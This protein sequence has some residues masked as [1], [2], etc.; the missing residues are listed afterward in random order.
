MLPPTDKKK[1]FCLQAGRKTS[2]SSSTSTTSPSPFS[3]FSSFLSP[4]IICRVGFI[5]AH[6]WRK[7]INK[8]NKAV[9]TL[10]K[11]DFQDFFFREK[12][13]FFLPPP[14]FSL[15]ANKLRGK[16]TKPIATTPEPFGHNKPSLIV[17]NPYISS[18]ADKP[19]NNYRRI[20]AT[21]CHKHSH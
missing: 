9:V 15:F 10:R 6:R 7:E 11:V 17:H 16:Q 2:K 12:E 20:F 18:A 14:S 13:T 4:R 19:I 8:L 3:L 1:R 21:S 5:C